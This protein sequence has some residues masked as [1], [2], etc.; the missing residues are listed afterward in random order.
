M[1]LNAFKSGLFPLSPTE[2]TCFKLVQVKAGNISD[3][4]F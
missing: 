2:C 4:L 3:N 1:V